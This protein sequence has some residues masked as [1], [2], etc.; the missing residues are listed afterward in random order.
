MATGSKTNPR[1]SQMM[2]GVGSGRGVN[3]CV[4]DGSEEMRQE[5][6]S[7]WKP[8]FILFYVRSV[9]SPKRGTMHTLGKDLAR[10]CWMKYAAPETSCRLSSVQRA[11]GESMTVAIRK[12]LECLVSLSQVRCH[13][14]DVPSSALVTGTATAS[15]LNSDFVEGADR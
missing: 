12:M 15:F 9:A 4:V 13:F 2:E 7:R 8:E 6:L 5:L 10:Y 1:N 14:L 11:P 3:H